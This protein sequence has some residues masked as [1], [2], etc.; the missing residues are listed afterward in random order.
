MCKQLSWSH[1]N[2]S[3]PKPGQEWFVAQPRLWLRLLNISALD[4]C[5]LVTPCLQFRISSSLALKWFC[6]QCLRQQ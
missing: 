5:I 4:Y 1:E 2:V 6:M 3:K